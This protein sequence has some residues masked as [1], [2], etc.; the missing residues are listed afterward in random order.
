MKN[1]ISIICFSILLNTSCQNRDNNS[2]VKTTDSI[3]IPNSNIR[4]DTDEAAR[5]RA[6]TTDIL[7]VES[8]MRGN[9]NLVEADYVFIVNFINNNNDE[10]SSEE[11]GYTLFQYLRKNK[12]R[13]ISFLNFISKRDKTYQNIL[14]DKLIK[15]MCIDIGEENYTYEKLIKDFALFANNETIRKSLKSCAG[16]EI[17]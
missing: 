5:S 11:F 7:N 8:K 1:C 14:L 16:N 13:N 6:D 4:N 10:S 9:K 3:S 15:I 12:S 2:A 17:Q